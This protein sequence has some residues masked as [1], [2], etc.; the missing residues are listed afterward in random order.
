[1]KKSLLTLALAAAVAPAFALPSLLPA[2]GD[3]AFTSFNADEDGWSMVS[4]VDIAAGA[5]V[6]FTDNEWSGT[7]FN[8]GESYLSW[9]TG[10]ISAG[11]VIRF[12]ATDKATL[13]ASNGTLARQSVSGSTNYGTSNSDDTI[14]AYLGSSA[15]APTSFLAAISNGSFGTASSGS[16]TNTGL[17]VGAGAVQLTS[18]SDYAE[19]NGVRDGQLAFSAYKPLVSNVANW[20]VQGDVAAAAFVP[21]TTA[22]SVSAVPEPSSYAMLL[23]GLALMGGIASRRKI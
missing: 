21:N 2:T 7:A 8:T 10:A 3:L 23:A 16:L 11:D 17:S 4:F 18:S 22:F 6:Y 14:Y 12:F 13:S 20:A 15:T 9:T 5:T 19:Y 1:M